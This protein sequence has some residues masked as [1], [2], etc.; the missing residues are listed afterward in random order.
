MRSNKLL[1]QLKNRLTWLPIIILA[2]CQSD[3]VYHSYKPVP[4]DGWNQSDTIVYTLPN[5]IPTGNY[6]VKIGIRYQESYPYRD[7]WLGISH[8]TEDTLTYITDTLQLFL[9]DEVG[10]KTG[11]GPCGLYQCDLPYK[12]SLHFCMEGNTRTFR[13]VHI[14]TDNPLIGITDV[15]IQLRKVES[16]MH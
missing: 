2:A 14:M 12:A 3:I 13:I 11:N 9:V 5:Y 8:N 1:H 6:E 10:N 16:P 7:L 4:L 15:G